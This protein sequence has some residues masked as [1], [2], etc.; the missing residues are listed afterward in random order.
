MPVVEEVEKY[1]DPLLSKNTAM[2][3]YTT[4]KQPAFKILITSATVMSKKTF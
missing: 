4:N 3:K 1:S 2:S